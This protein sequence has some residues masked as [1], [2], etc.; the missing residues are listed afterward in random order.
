[1]DNNNDNDNDDNDDNDDTHPPRII[2]RVGMVFRRG[3]KIFYIVDCRKKFFFLYNLSVLNQ[4]I[5][6]KILKSPQNDTKIHIT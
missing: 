4:N 1:M 3:Q 6:K 5:E 2:V